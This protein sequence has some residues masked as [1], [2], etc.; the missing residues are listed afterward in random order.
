MPTTILYN[1]T[2]YTMD[3]AQPRAQAI[4]INDGRVVA[5]GS[6]GKVQAA[7]G[8]TAEGIN[9]RGRAAIP[10]LTDAHV[11]L[12]WHALARQTVRLDGIADFD[13]VLRQITP[14]ATAGSGWLQGG[15]WDH[16]LWGGRWPTAADLDKI[17]PERPAMLTRKDGHA[18]WLN[19]AALITAGIDET[20][21]DPVG[22]SIRRE[23]GTPTGILYETA[24]DLAR[25]H[26]TEIGTEERMAA[27]RE[28]IVEAH[29]YGMVGMHIPTSMRAGDGLMHLSDIQKLREAGK[30]PLRCLQYIGLDG[31]DDALRLGIRSGMGDRWIRIGGVKM[32]ADGSL[33]SETA[34]MLAPYESGS[35]KG[36]AT[37]PTDEL[38]D[39]VQRAMQ[40]GLSVMVHAIGDAANRK[41]LDA[42]EAAMPKRSE[43][44]R[45]PSDDSETQYT[46]RNAQYRIPNRIEHCQIVHPND[47]PRFA[48]LGVIASMQPIHCTADMDTAD[49][50]WGER[51]AT[52]YAWRALKQAGAI[53]AFGSD[54]PVES[55]NPWLS[56]HAAVTRQKVNG[57][58]TGGWYT[59]QRLSVHEALWGFTVG[60]A[61]AAGAAHE[62]GTLMPGMLADITV[63]TQDPFKIDPSTLHAV[64]SDMTILE[65]QVVWERRGT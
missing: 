61:T 12:I 22:G 42:I 47:I 1:G 40:G 15:G 3:P 59:S 5:V 10:A 58:P 30:L 33:G 26:I 62:Q 63:L 52:A 54:A 19:T 41:V 49:K 11:H 44:T 56:I 21:P 60:A 51:C 43:Q 8:R 48:K 4:A 34:E 32:F 14:F 29:S 18:A 50:L 64:Q 31:L 36:L 16:T 53:L 38:F 17:V 9:L 6:E 20:T 7:V 65:G 2:I 13:A 55:L 24:I 57:S 39:A 35:G 27:V 28:A 25:R 45:S 46:I 37:M 23:H